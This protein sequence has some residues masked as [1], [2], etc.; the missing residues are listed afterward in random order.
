MKFANDSLIKMTC[1]IVLATA[2]FGAGS[3]AMAQSLFNPTPAVPPVVMPAPAPAAAQPAVAAEEKKAVAKPAAKPAAAK[4]A[5]K[6]AKKPA[7]ASNAS[8]VLV[9]NK[10]KVALIEL[11]VTS[12]KTDDAKPQTIASDLAGGK[13]TSAALAKN[14]GCLYDISGL[15]SDESVVEV[16]GADLCKD[17]TISLVE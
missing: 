2:V 17:S 15:F 14:G 9:V 13:R 12:T 11:V 16:N 4:P 5:A 10:R 8:A 3:S 6:A 7:Q 1:T